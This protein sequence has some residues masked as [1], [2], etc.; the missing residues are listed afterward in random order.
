MEYILACFSRSSLVH[1]WVGSN[2]HRGQNFIEF[3]QLLT[4]FLHLKCRKCSM[5]H[6]A[7]PDT[8]IWTANTYI[9]SD[10]HTYDWNSHVYAVYEALA[11]TNSHAYT[12]GDAIAL[13][14]SQAYSVYETLE[15]TNSH[16]YT[17]YE[18][19]ALTNQVSTPLNKM[20]IPLNKVR[21]PPN[22]VITPLKYIH[23]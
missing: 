12:I 9:Y 20:R 1:Y 13:T 11:L 18:T 16:A 6:A 21:T 2:W 10:G 7:F 8:V 4:T 15:I 3:V 14:N 19:L 5:L 22:K 17:V 23:L